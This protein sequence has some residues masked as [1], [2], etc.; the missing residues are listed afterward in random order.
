[1]DSPRIPWGFPN[2]IGIP[3]ADGTAEDS[4]TKVQFAM[5]LTANAGNDVIVSDF[6][7]T[8]RTSVKM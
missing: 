1:M 2:A 5:F 7:L 6:E 3:A 8:L 4:R